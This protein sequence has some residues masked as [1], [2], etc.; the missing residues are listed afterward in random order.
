MDEK[1]PKAENLMNKL[2]KGNEATNC[3]GSIFGYSR[4]S[5]AVFKEFKRHSA[6]RSCSIMEL[7]SNGFEANFKVDYMI[8]HRY[9]SKSI[10]FFYLKE[11]CCAL[12]MLVIFQWINY[13]YL[14]EIAI[15]NEYL[16]E[17][18]V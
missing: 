4:L 16:E 10:S 12:I 3:D 6:T 13:Q 5:T 14:T 11:F 8:Q 1:D 15:A 18:V 17:T 9:R 7:A 2:W